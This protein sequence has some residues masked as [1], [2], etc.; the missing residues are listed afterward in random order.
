MWDELLKLKQTAPK[1]AF[2][3]KNRSRR[4][5]DAMLLS[6]CGQALAVASVCIDRSELFIYSTMIIASKSHIES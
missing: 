4:G 6:C 1:Y 3:E 2:S 5:P